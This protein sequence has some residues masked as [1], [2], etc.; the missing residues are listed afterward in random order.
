[1]P[2]EPYAHITH[3][4]DHFSGAYVRAVCAAVG[5]GCDSTS[6]DN[7]KVDYIVSSRVSGRVR[8]KPKIDIQTKCQMSGEVTEGD[9]ISYPLDIDTYDNLRDVLVS[10]PRYLVLV[11]T[12]SNVEDWLV[13]SE[14]ELTFKHCAYWCSLKGLPASE[15]ATTQTVYLPRSNIF[16]PAVLRQMMERASNGEDMP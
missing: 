1:M 12:P 14:Q 16:T 5:C 2:P 3:R 11:V 7:D 9:R 15:N 13:Q 4:Q 6:L 8:T 10:N